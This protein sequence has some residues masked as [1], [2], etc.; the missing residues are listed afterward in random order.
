[1][2]G[3]IR[4][5]RIVDGKK[6]IVYSNQGTVDYIKG[7][8]TLESFNPTSFTGSS[9]DIII[10]PKLKDIKPLR[11]QVV[12]ISE[13]NISLTMNDVSSVRSGLITDNGS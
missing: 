7:T 5:Y 11:E 13:S 1:M 8:I 4:V 3:V 9:L 12:L 2:N 10:D 6:N